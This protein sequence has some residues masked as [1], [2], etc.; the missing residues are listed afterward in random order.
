MSEKVKLTDLL[1]KSNTGAK[2]A[3]KLTDLLAEKKKLPQEVATAAAQL[4]SEVSETTSEES[5]APVSQESKPLEQNGTLEDVLGIKLPAIPKK[6]PFNG[7]PPSFDSPEMKALIDKELKEGKIA[8]LKEFD[9][10]SQVK[11]KLDS[12]VQKTRDNLA[13]VEQYPFMKDIKAINEQLAAI[14]EPNTPQKAEAQKALVNRYNEIRSAP[15]EAYEQHEE[16][17]V[18][19][20]PDSQGNPQP[21]QLI[22][23]RGAYRKSLRDNN[24]KLKG[25]KTVGDILDANDIEIEAYNELLPKAKEAHA[26]LEQTKKDYHKATGYTGEEMGGLEAMGHSFTRTLNDMGDFLLSDDMKRKVWKDRM[27]EEE[28]APKEAKGTTGMAG[29]LAGGLAPYVIGGVLTG[30]ES[31]MANAITQ[32]VLGGT[33]AGGSKGYET[34]RE[35]VLQGMP[36]PEA[37]ALA[38]SRANVAAG[39]GAVAFGSMGLFGGKALSKTVQQAVY[40][41]LG[42]RVAKET[43]TDAM[44]ETLKHQGAIAAIFGA[45][46]FLNNVYANY[47]GDHKDLSEGVAESMLTP[48]L[49]G[50]AIHGSMK[51][52]KLGRSAPGKAYDVY[53]TY[54]AKTKPESIKVF[55]EEAIKNGENHAEVNKLVSDVENKVK[56][57]EQ[58]PEMPFEEL[59]AKLPLMQQRDALVAEKSRLAKPFHEEIDLQ[60]KAIDEKLKPKSEQDII[61]A[62][63]AKNKQE[64]SERN[65]IE[66]TPTITDEP[67]TTGSDG[68]DGNSKGAKDE[69][70]DA[71][72]PADAEVNSEGKQVEEV[73]EKVVEEA[74]VIHQHPTKEKPYVTKSGNA[75]IHYEPNTRELVVESSTQGKEIPAST[76][77][78][79]VREYKDN[80]KYDSGKDY[81]GDTDHI[82]QVIDETNNP[83]ELGVILAGESKYVPEDE[84]DY[85]ERAIA[86]NIGHVKRSSYIEHGDKNN[87]TMSLAK[88]YLRKDGTPLDLIAMQATEE[89]YGHYDADNPGIT[90]QDVIDFMHRHPSKERFWKQKSETFEKARNRFRDLTGLEPDAK[91]IK[92]ASDEYHSREKNIRADKEGDGGD[93]PKSEGSLVEKVSQDI[94]SKEITKLEQAVDKINSTKEKSRE[95]AVEKESAKTSTQT[96][97]EELAKAKA[98][99]KKVRDS[100]NNLRAVDDPFEQAKREAEADRKVFDAYVNVAKEYIKQ[101]IKSVEEFAKEI[102]E[103]VSDL[104]KGAWETANGGIKKTIT[105]KRAYEGEFREGVKRELENLGLTRDV[106]SQKGAKEQAKQFIDSVGEETA[107]EAVR[108]NDVSDAAG[109]YVW[110]ELIERND[111]RIAIEKDPAKL[112]ELQKEQANLINELSRKA[113]SGGR[114]SSALNDVYQS[115]DL[116]YN[117]EKKIQE[118][119]DLNGGEIS[120]EQEARFRELDKQYQEVKKQLVEAEE[121]ARIAEEKQAVADIKESVEREKKNKK[122][123][124]ARAKVVANEIRKLKSKPIELRDE[125]GNVIDLTTM[126]VTWNDI[127]ETVAKTVEAGGKVADALDAALKDAE[128]FAKLSDKGREAVKQQLSGHIAGLTESNIGKLNI[129]KSLIR[130]L[131]ESGIDNID[132]LTKAVHDKY[133]KYTEREVRD[134]ITGYGKTVNPNMQEVEVSIRKMKRAGRIISALEDIAEKKRPLR[135]GIQRDKLDVEER[136]KQKEL[137]EAMKE[138]PLDEADLEQELKTQ[139]DASKQ[140]VENQIEDLEREIKNGELTPKNARTVKED[141]ELKALKEKRDALKKEHEAIFKDE[142]YKE[143]RRLELT[144]K[145]NQRRIEDLERRLK[146]KD[147]SKK[148]R[149]PLISDS[150]LI[151]IKAEKLRLQEEYDKEFY[152][153]KLLNRTRGEKIKDGLWDAWGLTRG[154]SATGE[155]SFVGIQGLI[156]TIAH[157]THAAKAFKNM[158]KFF[159]SPAKAEQWLREIKSQDFYPTMKDAK[160]ALTEPHAEVTAREELFY[161]GWTDLIWNTIGSPLKLKSPEAFEKWKA[162]NPIK[163]IERG[164]VGYLDTL[165]VERF[166]DGMEILKEQGKTIENSKQDYKDVADAIN[167]LTGRGSLGSQEMNAEQLSKL[168]FSPRNWSAQFKTATP[169]AL[170]HFGKMTPTARKMAIA[171][172]SKFVGLTTSMVMMSAAYLNNDD[173]PETGVEFDPRSSDFMKLKIGNRR[174]D[175]WGGRIQQVVFTSRLMMDAIHDAFPD[176]SDGGMKTSKGEVVPLGTPFKASTKGGVVAKMAVNKLAP[177][178]HLL[179]SY[180]MAQEKKDGTKVDEYGKPYSFANELKMSLAPIYWGQTLPDLLK[181][182]PTALDG[183]LAAGAFFGMGVNV[184]GD[185]K[186]TS[187]SSI[188]AA[189]KAEMNKLIQEAKKE[190]RNFKPIKYNSLT[191]KWE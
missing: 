129:S 61:E 175:P 160:L 145:A 9:A 156:Q 113:L 32:A 2:P 99:A 43:A 126:G 139:L 128:W 138:L 137:R 13:I 155:A 97:L 149:K 106:E 58:M 29:E 60:I 96:A 102:G 12:E 91:T 5:T 176:A 10:N 19:N 151:K 4:P 105:T 98:E 141:A 132:D 36:E 117:V 154:L 170:Y 27:L 111:K 119:K 71:E 77:Q 130:D 142:E 146:E 6:K 148:E 121:R 50:A 48:V 118:F 123:Y 23:D 39:T 188:P 22:K 57:I 163:A 41:G 187:T 11:N 3:V 190:A 112:A 189:D 158:A 40:E 38:N 16:G 136:A 15:I 1:S 133:P 184:Y 74:P 59:Q 178:A 83:A 169:Y 31:W 67:N 116:G 93:A 177:S 109:A 87:I 7:T 157:P 122:T 180:M 110:G 8:K 56:A 147:F 52:I 125:N 172:F 181:D 162:A 47:T 114:F 127:V 53:T 186:P 85:K 35:S 92:L 72:T 20:I 81:E 134:A 168:F 28:V 24:P 191:G 171:D 140:R 25:L 46:K 152:K 165:R 124:T 69:R 107:L 120:P 100:K 164:A 55:A 66:L 37:M 166:L 167:T 26:K 79:Y 90:E 182:D 70:V 78:K 75:T 21:I 104:M 18:I 17:S 94:P 115:S 42:G 135:S 88:E 131:V 108:N 82:Y 103:D 62:E 30:G 51:A 45:D 159:A 143:A 95:G 179:E 174:V 183:L 173:D 101:G 65:D 89:A 150:E 185:K 73:G 80:Y 44:I 49:L 86:N 63:Q 33:S 76:K 54:I 144:K 84:L 34:Y 14:G 68:Q 153:Q 161:S 64:Q